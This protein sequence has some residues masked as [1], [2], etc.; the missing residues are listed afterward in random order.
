MI[1][2]LGR[3]KSYLDYGVFQPLQIAAIIA[4]REC[5]EETTKICEVYQKRRDVLV[6]GLHRAGWM[7]ESPRATIDVLMGKD[8]REV[9]MG[10]LARVF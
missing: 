2:A 3:I 6:A 10:R 5:E 7:V 1:S 4:L 9:P 8:P